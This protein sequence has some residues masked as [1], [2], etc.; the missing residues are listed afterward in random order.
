M[1]TQLTDLFNQEIAFL[2]GNPL[3]GGNMVFS[4]LR[5]ANNEPITATFTGTFAGVKDGYTENED[6]VMLSVDPTTADLFRHLEDTYEKSDNF[7]PEF[8]VYNLVYQGDVKIKLRHNNG[9]YAKVL[10]NFAPKKVASIAYGSPISVSCTIG[11]YSSN[12]SKTQGLFITP[13]AVRTN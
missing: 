9:R 11:W 4:S 1:Q 3:K 5:T 10:C 13:K 12:E 7:N 6:I 8:R 2:K